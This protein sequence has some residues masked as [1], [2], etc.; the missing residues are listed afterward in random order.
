LRGGLGA[1]PRGGIREKIGRGLC[2]R[3]VLNSGEFSYNSMLHETR[4]GSR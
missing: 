1:D 3:H 4:Y 2:W